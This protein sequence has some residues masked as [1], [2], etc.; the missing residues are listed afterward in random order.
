[1][2]E[3]I[4]NFS[5]TAEGYAAFRPQSPQEIYDFLYQHVNN[6]TAAWDCG[7]GNGQ[8]AT[9]LV[10]RFGKVYGTDISAEQLQRAPQLANVT[11]LQERA[12]ETSIASQSVDLI[13]VAQAIHW[14]DFD[15]FYK[16]VRRVAAPGALVAAW[17]LPPCNCQHL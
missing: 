10:E 9:R 3:T 1:M 15:A 13:T 2:K 5:A 11:Y 17:T 14:F 12:E 16:E 6:Y 8:V 4:D 7:T